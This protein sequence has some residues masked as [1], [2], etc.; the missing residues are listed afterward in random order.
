[1]KKVFHTIFI[2]ISSFFEDYLLAALIITVCGAVLIT[3]VILISAKL[4]G[5]SAKTAFKENLKAVCSSALILFYISLILNM[6]VFR[7]LSLPE[8]D[9]FSKIFGGWGIEDMIY[10]YDF[11]SI[12]NIIMFLPLCTV[13]FIFIKAA[14]NRNITDKKLTLISFLCGFVFSC[15]IEALQIIL[16]AGTFQIADIFYNTLGGVLSAGIFILLRKIYYSASLK[17]AADKIKSKLKSLN[18][19]RV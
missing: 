10:Y 14:L 18:S 2:N 9:P 7:R 16:K 17:K 4:K 3:A 5:K 8:H 12:F 6:T 15:A 19:G 13:L 11:S 1:M